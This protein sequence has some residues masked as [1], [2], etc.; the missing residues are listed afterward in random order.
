MKILEILFEGV[1]LEA[2]GLY[3]RKPGDPFKDEMGDDYELLS[4]NSYP[5]VGNYE[6][7]DAMVKQLQRISRGSEPVIVNKFNPKAH[8]AFG[9]AIFLNKKTGAKRDYVKYFDTISPN[10]MGKWANSEI[11]GLSFQSGASI[12]SKSNYK[13][14]NLLAGQSNFKSGLELYH[15]L[16]SNDTV[17]DD[18]KQ[19]IE[20]L[21][22]GEMPVFANNKDNLGEIRDYLS[23]ILD[24]LVVTMAPN[25]LSGQFEIAHKEILDSAP[26]N[27]LKIEFPMSQT[28][29]FADCYLVSKS[30]ERLG[31]SSKGG[32]GANASAKNIWDVLKA[33]EQKNKSLH[34]KYSNAV[35]VIDS[36]AN[37]SSL[38]GPIKLGLDLDIINQKQ[39]KEIR[40]HIN[41]SERNHSK[42]SKWAQ[43]YLDSYETT[44]P[45]GWNYGYWLLAALAKKVSEKINN[46]KNFGK[47][48]VAFL[49]NSNIIQIYAKASAKGND[50]VFNA[51]DAIY[52][53]KFDG[54][55]RI[56]SGKTYSASGIKGRFTFSFNKSEAA[57][58]VDTGPKSNFATGKTRTMLSPKEKPKVKTRAKR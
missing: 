8:K 9:L 39:A 3:A 7:S 6:T 4:I 50:V 31:I 21:V 37:T 2:R 14:Q 18:I 17:S 48:F 33:S 12:K 26:L 46:D 1:L 34:R 52:P 43:G 55:V 40:D 20:M 51:F 16:N 36:I 49:N 44:K 53:A 25:L 47:A 11:P 29:G 13:P 58:V 15:Y 30:G 41:N 35:K 45:E 10:M 22:G 42:L 5:K 32:K 56:E 23:E 57:D 27:Q 19:G 54:K 28:T 24:P 38:E